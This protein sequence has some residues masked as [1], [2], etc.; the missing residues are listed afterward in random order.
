M[1]LISWNVNGLRSVL[2][3]GFLEHLSSW[4]ADIL[5]L[6]ETKASREIM[7]EL[8]PT[9]NLPYP[10]R[11]FHS[12]ERRGYAGVAIF[13]QREPERVFVPEAL[14]RCSS[15]DEGRGLI[16]D[17]GDFYVVTLYVPN[18]GEGLRRLDLRQGIWDPACAAF[19]KDLA[20]QKPTIVGG[21]FNVAHQEI[22]LARPEQNRGNAGF[23]DPE[24]EGFARILRAGFV[25]SFRHL[26]PE[27]RG[28]YSWWSL[29]TA[30]RARHIG[31]RIDYVLISRNLCPALR[32]AFILEDVLGSDHAPVGIELNLS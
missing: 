19:L 4:K 16:Q 20:A 26:H 24:R 17:Y 27:K 2:K 21:D 13:S 7:E 22:D 25:D 31:W 32:D 1:R 29:R 14:A 28:A 15:G 23:T 9:L 30:A 6:Q 8:L 3:K 10:V 11:H 12:A 18:S 5:C